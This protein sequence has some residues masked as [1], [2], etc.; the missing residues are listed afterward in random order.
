MKSFE[1]LSTTYTV[2][3]DYTVPLKDLLKKVQDTSDFRNVPS[4]NNFL[5]YGKE[6]ITRTIKIISLT[7]DCTTQKLEQELSDANLRPTVIEE[8]ATFAAEY[9]DVQK[10]F[11]YVCLSHPRM[12]IRTAEDPGDELVPIFTY[13]TYQDMNMN[14]NGYIPKKG[15]IFDL[16]GYNTTWPVGAH[17]IVVDKDIY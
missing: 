15:R 11:E 14:K 6:K 17:F 5:I 13:G 7:A 2:V 3:V 4:E 8:A 12:Y 16:I 1:I 9:P 10:Q